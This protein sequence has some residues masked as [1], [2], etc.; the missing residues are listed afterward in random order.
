MSPTEHPYAASAYE[1]LNDQG[2]GCQVFDHK[3]NDKYSVQ[4]DAFTQREFY[5][6][7]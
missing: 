7:D 4:A 6:N 3:E 2:K 1:L 5:T